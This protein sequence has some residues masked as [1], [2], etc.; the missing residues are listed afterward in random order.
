MGSGKTTSFDIAHHAGVSQ[1]TVS[2]ALRDSPLVNP[3]TR[4]RIKRIAL[5][6]DYKVDRNAAGLRSQ[7]SN[8][9]A[10]LLFQD[11]TSDD[12]QINP[13]FLSMLGN[14]TR[15]A[16]RHKY[17]VLVSF[18]QLS[19]DWHGEY[20]LS[21]RADGMILLGYG[22][23]LQF[24]DKLKKLLEAR[25][26]FIIWGAPVPG[27]TGHA[28][29]CHN[30]RGASDATRHL[31]GLGRRHIAFLGDT[32][33]RAPE[34]QRRYQGYC[35]ALEQAGLRADPALQVTADNQ[36]SSGWGAA[37]ELLE[38]GQPFDAILAASDLIAIGA[39]RKL[40]HAGINVPGDVSVV[41]FDDIPAA[42]YFSPSLTTVRQDTRVAGESLVNNLIKLIEGKSVQS[43]MLNP[44][45]VVRGSCGGR[46]SGSA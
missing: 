8:T 14:I 12:S 25:A 23:Y 11:P 7:H 31:A 37:Q 5:E 21:N 34:L 43:Q 33:D 42:S 28:I 29:G 9:I 17:D 27:L 6:L 20:E 3:K 46:D 2:R 22:D 35:E 15:A 26:H 32:T 16:A 36:E 1:A 10:L 38:S 45:L 19:E 24:S 30:A 13:F 44:T 18:Q 40:R 39:I 41:G 4:E